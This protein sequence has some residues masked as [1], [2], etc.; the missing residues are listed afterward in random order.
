MQSWINRYCR[1]LEITIALFLAV[2][3]VLVF[4]NVVLRYAMD[5]GIT[6]SEELSRWLFV[7]VTF[8]G[9]ILAFREHQHLGTNVL[10]DRIGA[11]GKTLLLIVSNLAMLWITWLLLVGSWKQAV[12][13]RNVSAPVSGLPMAIVYAAGVVFSIS[14]LFLLLIDLVALLRD[15]RKKNPAAPPVA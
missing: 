5:S 2:M 4:G 15:A 13:N 10:L 7:W 8:L 14:V 12:I 1:L 3:V 9:S 11:F 6:L